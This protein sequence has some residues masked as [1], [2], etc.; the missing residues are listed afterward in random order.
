MILGKKE[1]PEIRTKPSDSVPGKKVRR[2]EI[3]QQL[4]FLP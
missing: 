1:L 3:F 2:N 4:N